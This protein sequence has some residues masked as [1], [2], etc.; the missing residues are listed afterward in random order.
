M[1]K[2]QHLKLINQELRKLN[3]VID[4]KITQHHNYRREAVRHKKLLSEI[5]RREVKNSFSVLLR[6]FRPTWL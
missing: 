2:R 5:R 4:R 6:S 1:S 3:E